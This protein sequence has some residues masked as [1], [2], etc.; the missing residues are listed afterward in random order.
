MPVWHEG[1]IGDC[2]HATG[3]ALK[4][5]ARKEQELMHKTRALALTAVT[6]LVASLTGCAVETD[7]SF[8]SATQAYTSGSQCWDNSGINALKAALAVSMASELGRVDPVRDLALSSS[9]WDSYVVLTWAAKSQCS[10]RGYGDCPNTQAILSLQNPQVNQ[11]LS[12]NSFNATVFKEELKAS[13]ERQRNRE[14]DLARNN[15]SL[16]PQPH[17]LTEIGISNYGACGIHYDFNVQGNK[18][19]NL[20]YRMEFYGGTQNPFIAFRSTE[21]TISIDPTG[22]M[23]GDTTASSGACTVGCYS[24]GTALRDTCCSCDGRQGTYRRAPWNAQM[25]YCAY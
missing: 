21:R 23:N 19:E 10:S 7:D 18:P 5:S 6:T 17:V 11:Y 20:Q 2:T 8:G 13:F 25:N 16:L 15:P 14:I 9:N 22:T 1:C 3:C 24:Y 12:Y 4:R